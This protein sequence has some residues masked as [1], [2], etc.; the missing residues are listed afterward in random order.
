MSPELVKQITELRA[1]AKRAKRLANT[2]SPADEQLILTYAEE[3]EEQAARLEA[4]LGAAPP[5]P[6]VHEQQQAQQQTQAPDET[7]PKT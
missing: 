7:K 4:Q 6:V 1:M 3:L 5:G 2:V